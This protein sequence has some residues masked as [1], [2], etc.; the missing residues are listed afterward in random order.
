MDTK[1]METQFDEITH[2]TSM[3]NMICLVPFEP[4]TPE[5]EE[6]LEIALAVNF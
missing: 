5:E 3:D 2:R 6:E 1:K 4:L